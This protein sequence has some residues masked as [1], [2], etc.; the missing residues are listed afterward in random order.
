MCDGGA[1]A[2]IN[3]SGSNSNTSGGTAIPPDTLVTDLPEA[4][5]AGP[6]QANGFPANLSPIFMLTGQ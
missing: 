5:S 1:I 2:D 4:F 3:A 6:V